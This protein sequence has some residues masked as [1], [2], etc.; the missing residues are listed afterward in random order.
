MI[1][2]RSISGGAFG[3]GLGAIRYLTVPDGAAPAPSHAVS[4]TDWVKQIMQTFP[5]NPDG[6]ATGNLLFFVHGFNEAIDD[7][8]K[9]HGDITA[10][11][12]GKLSCTVVSFDWPSEAETFA[13]LP[14][15]DTA[16]RTAI[17]LVNAG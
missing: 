16:K 12:A 17:D 15:L 5:R 7:V 8:V 13:Y 1:T 4:R 3:G 10:G 14:D 6:N 11:L 9:L 2:V